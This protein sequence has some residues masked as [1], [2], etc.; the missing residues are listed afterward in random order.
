MASAFNVAQILDK[1]NNRDKDF[2]FMAT[3]DLANELEKETFKLDANAEPK[4]VTQLLKL[5]EDPAN[6]VQENSVKCL[7][8]LVKRVKEPQSAEIVDTLCNHM[9]NEKKDDLREISNIGLKTVIAQMVENT[10]TP[11]SVVKRLTPRLIGGITASEKPEVKTCCLDI[12]ND[13]LQRFGSLILPDIDKVQ[14]VVQPHL[15]SGRPATR[16]RA[17]NCLGH[18]AV[19]I[20]DNLF[21][22]LIDF[23][24]S[25][26]EGSKKADDIR[27]LIQAFGAISRS[28]GY[29]LGKYLP[30]IVPLIVLHSDAAKAEDDELREN[31]FQAFESLVLRCPKDISPYL[32]D[33]INLSLK[34]IKYDPNYAAEDEG[35]EE[36]DSE[37]METDEGGEEAEEEADEGGDVSDDEDMSWKVR[38]AATK[39]LSAI[40]TTRPELLSEL[41]NKVAPVLISRFQEREE[42]VKLDVFST[43]IDLLKQTSIVSRR[44]DNNTAG[45]LT[46][47]SDLTP[48]IVP[49]LTKQLSSKSPKTRVG[50]F[51]LLK[52]LV[53][54]RPGALTNHIAAIVP[55][56]VFSLGDKGTN[57]NLKIEALTFLRLLLSSHPET[58]FHPHIK[59]LTPPILKAVGESYYRISAE[60]LRVLSELVRVIRPSG[61]QF[62]YAPYVQQVYQ[63][64]LQQL[65]AQDIDQ[66]VK[67]SA[68]NCT[69]IIVSTL[70][71]GLP[72]ADLNA[73]LALLL[74]RLRNEI[75]RVNAVKAVARIA[76]SK[77]KIDISSILADTMKELATFLRKSNRQ[78]KQSS[79]SALDSVVRQYGT[80]KAAIALF[81]T[82]FIEVS[83][84]ISDADLHLSH[85]ALHLGVTI[86]SVHP[87]SAS[88][89]VEKILPQTLALL[90][91]SLL[92][93][94]AL[95]SLLSL[96]AELVAINAKGASF[97]QLS[98]ALLNLV[99]K[100]SD[101]QKSELT[102]Q[103]FSSISQTIAAITAKVTDAKKRNDTVEKFIKEV[104]SS[105]DDSLK[106]LSLLSLGEIGRRVDL[107]S[108]TSIQ[109]VILTAF[110]SASEELKQAASFALGNLSVGNLQKYLPFVLGEIKSQPKKQYLLLHSLREII[111]REAASG[112]GAATLQPYLTPILAL[113]FENCESEEE[114]TRNVVSECLGKFALISPDQIVPLLQERVRSPSAYARATV[115]TALKFTIL[116]QSLPIDT[117]LEPRMGDFLA[118]LSD[119]DLNVRRVTLL[120][121]NYAAHNKPSLIRNILPK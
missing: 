32:N 39:C 110:E 102:K 121:F 52:E 68:I 116:E 78:L 112:T 65:K 95:D 119:S 22:S 91:S 57:S 84:L 115:V 120:S 30:R 106:L 7:G 1:M 66:E 88:L 79:L 54:V 49:A 16:K 11:A 18:L 70:G 104:S 51:S 47:L 94:L 114:G 109:T 26:I 113:L 103:S 98:D 85:L 74:D 13:L 44:A 60:G 63:A 100:P 93:G 27:T 3:H 6:N 28:A 92:Q 33:I 81:P 90:R 17:I 80:N 83:P 19:L 2:R 86:L 55:G 45:P 42:N 38:R 56:I 105:K 23:L 82:V 118:L 15:T 41:Y 21:A 61:A 5:L 53:T 89:V 43:F 97:D 62:D 25:N 59:T 24:L 69:G 12:L 50:A 35:E 87:E 72:P 107:S 58:A 99:K 29:R 71:D 108:H 75:T 111:V 20:P 34:F 37:A 67:E 31:C 9:L 96:Y 46:L 64:A 101:A 40:I 36:E 10:N 8:L 48:K 4:I 14:K 77:L 76:Q 117:L 73:C